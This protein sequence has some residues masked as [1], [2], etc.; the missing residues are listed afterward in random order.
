MIGIYASAS[1]QA[2]TILE[3]DGGRKTEGQFVQ[4]SR[5]GNPLINEVVIP[6]GQ[7]DGWNR[8]E[9]ADDSAVHGPLREARGRSAREPP[10]RQR[11]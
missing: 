10:L 1:R 7:K 2:R 6:L 4:V 3:K 11:L 5:L 9:P 8:S